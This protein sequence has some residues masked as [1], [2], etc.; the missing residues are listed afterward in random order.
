MKRGTKIAA[1]SNRAGYPH[2]SDLEG[3]KS[4]FQD[5]SEATDKNIDRMKAKTLAFS[6]YSGTI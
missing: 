6:P 5:K 4:G 1:K 2:K 3:C